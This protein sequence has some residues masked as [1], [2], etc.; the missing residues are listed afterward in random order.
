MAKI[1]TTVHGPK[2]KRNPQDTTLQNTRA[3]NTRLGDLEQRV[4]KLEKKIKK[5]KRKKGV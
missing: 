5:L 3:A 1:E 4:R 2:P